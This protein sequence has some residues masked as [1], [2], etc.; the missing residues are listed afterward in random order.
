MNSIKTNTP[1]EIKNLQSQFSVSEKN[2]ASFLLSDT[3]RTNHIHLPVSV[4]LK[5]KVIPGSNNILS[6]SVPYTNYGYVISI[7]KNETFAMI[8]N[9][10]NNIIL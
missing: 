2:R 4:Q 8:I 7:H 10:D 3:S 5:N 9:F 1:T 6:G